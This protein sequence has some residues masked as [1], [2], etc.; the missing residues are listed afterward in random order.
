VT[1]NARALATDFASWTWMREARIHVVHNGLDPSRFLVD[2]SDS[3]AYLRRVAHAPDDAIMVGTVGRLAHEKDHQLFLRV[4]A[5]ARRTHV[6]LHGVVIGDGPLRVELETYAAS[7]G[8]T[9][10]VAFLGDRKDVVRV[11][12]GLDV[13]VLPSIIEG[14]PNALLEAVFLA[15]PSL[16]T[17]VG[18]CPDVL[19]DEGRT[20]DV[21]DE[22]AAL[23]A[24]LEVIEDRAS[25]SAV[26]ERVRRRALEVF[27]ATRTTATWLNL[28]ERC[29]TEAFQR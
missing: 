2:R 26:A 10:A 27:T 13:F 5:E 7:L 19:G 9:G 21:G 16:A 15:I 24:L 25:A 6:T 1:V 28:Y 17:N 3:R 12:A 4:V 11:M 8:L 18:G 29:L 22:A 23:R 20:F 14:F